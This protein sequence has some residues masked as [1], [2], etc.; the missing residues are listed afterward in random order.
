[1]CGQA[2]PPPDSTGDVIA[3]TRGDLD[4]RMRELREMITKQQTQR[5]N[6]QRRGNELIE[7]KVGVDHQLNEAFRA[8]DPAS[9]AN[10][11]AL[12]REAASLEQE[13]K[14]VEKLGAFLTRADAL[15]KEAERL[16][17][18]EQGIGKELRAAREAAQK[19]TGNLK[20]LSRLFADCLVRAKISGF[21]VDDKVVMDPPWYLP[22][23]IKADT[24]D[25]ATIS[26]ETLGSG[27]IKTLFKACFLLAMHRLAAELKAH[28]PTLIIIDSPMK[29]ISERENEA[30]FI[31]FHALIYELAEGELADNQFILIDK[32]F[33]PPR[34]DL[35]RTLFARHMKVNDPEFPPLI[36]YFQA[37][38]GGEAEQA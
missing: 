33:C 36:S 20:K 15:R 28:L 18:E 38:G 16:L 13:A 1:V 12:E 9:L 30:Q 24:G 23:V 22:E 27:G 11:V 17:L 5:R 34:R 29:N 26:F 19:D 35:T 14:Y 31:G 3:A 21:T 32:E 2:E 10:I 25:I 7:Q 37:D 4:A 8:Y 6:L